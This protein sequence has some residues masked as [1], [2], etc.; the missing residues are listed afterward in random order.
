MSCLAKAEASIHPL[1]TEGLQAS[2]P[3]CDASE[4]SVALHAEDTVLTS[5]T[6]CSSGVPDHLLGSWFSDK[7]HR[8]HWELP[9]LWFIPGDVCR[10][11]ATKGRDIQGRVWGSKCGTSHRPFPWSLGWCEHLLATVCDN[12]KVPT[13]MAT[14]G[15]PATPL[16]SSF[17]RTPAHTVRGAHR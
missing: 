8:A 3:A 17:Y 2:C 10:L 14:Q 13:S 12:R 9:S 16:V 4:F 7:A 1:K 5:D 6:S 15:S 11:N